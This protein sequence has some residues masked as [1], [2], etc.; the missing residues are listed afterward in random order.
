[1][2]QKNKKM[3]FLM[4]GSLGVVFGD[5]GTSPLYA[6]NIAINSVYDPAVDSAST[7]YGLVSLILWTITLVVSIKYISFIM[8]ADNKGEGGVMAL[9]SL[10]NSSKIK[11]KSLYIGLGIIGVALFYGDS[12]ITPAISL[13]SA[14]EGISVVAPTLNSIVVPITLLMVLLL[15]GVQKYGTANLGKYFGP[16]MVIWF[17]VI[18][19]G[20]LS[21]IAQQPSILNSISPFEGLGFITANP[22]VAFLSMGLVVLTITGAEALYADMGHFGRKP[23]SKTWFYIVFPALALCYM[24]QGALVLR[25]PSSLD[26]TFF[27]L[28]PSIVRLPIVVLATVTT[29]IAS[30]AVISGAFSITRQ[31]IQLNFLPRMTVIQTSAKTIGQIYLPLVNILMMFIVLTLVVL[32]RSSENLSGAY[33]IAVSGTLAI[34]SILFLVIIR[35][36]WN[37]SKLFVGLYAVIF[38][39]LDFILVFANLP[40]ILEGGWLPILIAILFIL[41]A[42]SWI[43]GQYSATKKRLSIELPLQEYIT[44]LQNGNIHLARLPGRAIYIGHH[45]GLTPTAMI[46]AV[47]ELHELHEQVVIVYVKTS[48]ES[49]IPPNERVVFDELGYADGISQV[50]ITYGFH[51]SPN[52]PK[53]LSSIRNLSPEV[54]FDPHL[55]SYFVSLTKIVLSKERT[56]PTWQK[57]LYIIMHRNALSLSDYYKLPTANTVD[58][59]TLIKI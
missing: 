26:N 39:T 33:G 46:T 49:H 5:I 25:D 13:I 41:I 48:S 54:N 7:V 9:V 17:T 38:L 36:F 34:D 8:R 10:I 4:I 51:D 40:K 57:K 20:G 28:F 52:I 35:K 44:K 43:R 21:Q 23:I 11:R 42:I 15:F 3:L 2:V 32:F 58:I 31:A 1:M 14:V 47:E 12:V 45:I 53:A 56:M 50:T 59:H 30:Q 29:L 27:L 19:V 16:I 24:G 18:G 6:F 37:R 22:K 55:A